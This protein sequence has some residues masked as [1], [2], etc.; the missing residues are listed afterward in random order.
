MQRSRAPEAGLL[1]FASILIDERHQ[2]LTEKGSRVMRS[3]W[4]ASA[5]RPRTSDSLSSQ[6][7]MRT[8][9]MLSHPASALSPKS[10]ASLG[11]PSLRPLRRTGMPG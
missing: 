2:G 5:S 7:A 11:A 3:E 4:S 1:L 9:A 8:A 6:R 10:A